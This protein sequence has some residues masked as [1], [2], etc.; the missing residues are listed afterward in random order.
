MNRLK[1]SFIATAMLLVV[2]CGGGGSSSTS[3][4]TKVETLE[5]A[6]SSFQALSA[7]D[8]MDGLSSQVTSNKLQKTSSSKA[9]S[10]SCDN[11]GTVSINVEGSS[12]SIVANKCAYG[13]YYMDGTLNMTDLSDGSEKFTMSNMTTK[14]GKIDMYISQMVFVD[15]ESE[16]WSTMDGDIKI[17]S[18][19]FSG[20]YKFETVEKIYEAQDDTDNV[21]SGVIDLNGAR[22]T[23]NNPTVTIKVGDKEETILQSDLEKKMNN[24]LTCSE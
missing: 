5:D 2:G 7:L 1:L 12:T 4:V 17:V 8:S 21:E 20:T 22:Y 6:K 19:C 13:N 10:A 14:D 9:Q 23:F 15:N 16:H 18:K 3:E 24:T 11:G